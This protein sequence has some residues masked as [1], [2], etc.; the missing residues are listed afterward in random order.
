ML[1]HCDGTDAELLK[2]DGTPCDCG[3]RFR[4]TDFKLVYPHEPLRGHKDSISI[5]KHMENKKARKNATKSTN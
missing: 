5:A 1:R 3:G 2:E 4:D